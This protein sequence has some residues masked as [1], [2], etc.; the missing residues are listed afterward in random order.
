MGEPVIG[1]GHGTADRSLIG[2][3]VAYRCV[4]DFGSAILDVLGAEEAVLV[5]DSPQVGGPAAAIV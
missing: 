5:G 4:Q 2:R 3:R 1:D